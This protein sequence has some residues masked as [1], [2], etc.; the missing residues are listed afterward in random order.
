VTPRARRWRQDP[1]PAA[2]R[3][4]LCTLAVQRTARPERCPAR[5]ARACVRAR[6]TARRPRLPPLAS[7]VMYCTVDLVNISFC[8]RLQIA[9][10]CACF[11]ARVRGRPPPDSET[12]AAGAMRSRAAEYGLPKLA[13]R[14]ATTHSVKAQRRPVRRD[15]ACNGSTGNAAQRMWSGGKAAGPPTDAEDHSRRK[16]GRSPMDGRRAGRARS[17]GRGADV[18]GDEVGSWPAG[19]SGQQCSPCL[20]AACVRR[21]EGK[22]RGVDHRLRQRR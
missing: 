8:A 3:A 9:E 17:R 14:A 19:G 18:E 21:T 22:R 6:F 7:C 2:S 4:D 10:R 12:A 11:W 1:P 16:E 5:A 13:A 15:K 20:A